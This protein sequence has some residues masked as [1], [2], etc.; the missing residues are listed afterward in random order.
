MS[1][2]MMSIYDRVTTNIKNT[3]VHKQD[4]SESPLID[5]STVPNKQ[6]TV[7]NVHCAVLSYDRY[8]K[9]EQKSKFTRN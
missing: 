6:A 3:P 4:R 5:Y 8:Q 9:T 2:M 1:F 7:G